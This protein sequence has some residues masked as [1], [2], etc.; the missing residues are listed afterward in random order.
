MDTFAIGLSICAALVQII[1]YVVYNWGT[2]SGK[3]KPNATSWFLWGL[4]SALTAWS[5]VALSQD[6]VKDLL[7]V[8]CAIVCAITFVFALLNGSYGKPDRYDLVV[9]ALDTVVILFWF[10]TDSDEYTNLLFQIDV[11]LSFVPIIRAAWKEPQNES[12]L[13]WFVWSV[14]Y[15][16]FVAVVL[17]RY[18]KWWDLMYPINYLALHLAVG[19]IAKFK[20]AKA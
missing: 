6:W 20:I 16:M 13:P 8:T 10:A 1:G 4:G 9:C 5:Y 2:F 17:M 11:I 14:A 19:L 15:V 18:E 12:A 3:I 7:P